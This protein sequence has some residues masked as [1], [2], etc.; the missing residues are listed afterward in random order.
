M[1]GISGGELLVVGLVTLLV[2]GPSKLPGAAK[3]A[4]QFYGRLQ[5]L[6]NEAK[7]TLKSQIDLAELTKSQS[8]PSHPPSVSPTVPASPPLPAPEPT[9]PET[10]PS[11]AEAI[12]PPAE[13]AASPD[14]DPASRT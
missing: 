8:D 1:F 2:L 14:E 11:A 3:T 10:S 12:L 9:A 5:R 13:A 4:G 6:L 7:T